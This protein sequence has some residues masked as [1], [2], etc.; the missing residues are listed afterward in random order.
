MPEALNQQIKAITAAH[1]ADLDKAED[2]QSQALKQLAAKTSAATTDIESTTNAFHNKVAQQALEYSNQLNQFKDQTTT[3]YRSDLRD[4]QRSTYLSM[5]FR[6]T[7]AL[8]FLLDDWDNLK[9]ED[10][11]LRVLTDLQRLARVKDSDL[12]KKAKSVLAKAK[13]YGELNN[14]DLKRMRVI[15]GLLLDSDT[16]Q[17]EIRSI[18]R[19]KDTP[20]NNTKLLELLGILDGLRSRTSSLNVPREQTL[21]L[22]INDFSDLLSR[23]DM[24]IKAEAFGLL[25]ASGELKPSQI[26]SVADFIREAAQSPSYFNAVVNSSGV[27]PISTVILKSLKDT[28]ATLQNS[29][30]QEMKRGAATLVTEYVT[31]NISKLELQRS[32]IDQ[33][34]EAIKSLN[35][36]DEALSDT[37]N[38]LAEAATYTWSV[39]ILEEQV[40]SRKGKGTLTQKNIPFRDASSYL[41]LIA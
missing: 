39:S 32:E 7:A 22:F 5:D 41:Q 20:E 33:I 40:E 19:A 23:T 26:K 9:S 15:D 36:G 37:L 2:T 4:L 3:K 25:T 27:L 35:L 31:R 24:G 28:L 38:D 12:Y 18:L 14:P 10:E 29:D 1:K 30:N 11:Q 16:V 34:R 8:S 17:N 6:T 13:P 21:G